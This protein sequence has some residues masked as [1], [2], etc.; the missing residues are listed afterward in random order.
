VSK[1][2]DRLIKSAFYLF[3]AFFL[4]L[5]FAAA[6]FARDVNLVWDASTSPTVD[7]YRLYTDIFY[8]DVGNVT[9]KTVT[10][11]DNAHSFQVS[12]TTSSIY[13]QEF[14]VT[15]VTTTQISWPSIVSPIT[16]RKIHYGT[17]S[18][19][20]TITIDIGSATNYTIT[21]LNPSTT[22]YFAGSNYTATGDYIPPESAK[23]NTVLILA[24]GQEPPPALNLA[25]SGT[26]YTWGTNSS[27]T[28]TANQSAQARLNDNLQDSF[29]INAPATSKSYV[30]AG[31][32]WTT[33]QTISTI[34]FANGLW[35]ASGDG[36]WTGELQLQ[37]T[38]NGTTWTNSGIAVSPVYA[39]NASTANITYQF[40]FSGSIRGFRIM[41]A[42]RTV[43]D[44]SW[45]VNL[46]EVFAANVNQPLNFRIVQ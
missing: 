3:V 29:A 20:Y 45:W 17:Q 14:I 2:L 36:S 39:Y 6:A 4:L 15:G 41:G 26:G 33:N 5:I 9:S 40:P 37:F 44:S 34:K 43:A 11:D 31:I 18:K 25:L 19:N 1:L 22:Y 42:V 12:A 35:D 30:G 28:G 10:V 23:S 13:G 21:G 27:I 8:Q 38:T 32:I 24:A 16:G 46:K 7:N